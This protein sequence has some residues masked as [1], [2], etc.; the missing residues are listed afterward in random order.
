MNFGQNTVTVKAS[1][2][3]AQKLPCFSAKTLVNLTPGLVQPS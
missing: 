1:K 3:S 2:L